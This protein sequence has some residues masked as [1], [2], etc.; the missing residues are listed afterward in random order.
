MLGNFNSKKSYKNNKNPFEGLKIDAITS[1]FGLQKIIN[2]PTRLTENSSSYIDL[3]F[4]FKS[5]PVMESG[6]HSSDLFESEF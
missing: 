2:E 1:Q 3:I 5:N 4:A 6:L